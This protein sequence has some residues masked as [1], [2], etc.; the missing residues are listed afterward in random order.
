MLLLVI[1]NL[2]LLSTGFS[3]I[4]QLSGR[5]VC[6]R[7][8]LEVS[9]LLLLLMRGE[10]LLLLR[11]RAAASCRL[12]LLLLGRSLL[13][14]TLPP[15]LT[16]ATWRRN[17][18]QK[19]GLDVPLRKR[20]CIFGGLVAVATSKVVRLGLVGTWTREKNQSSQNSIFPHATLNIRGPASPEKKILLRK[21]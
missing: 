2:F 8:L 14:L 18:L 5:L 3:P 11:V 4:Y 19:L 20:C 16:P 9:R 1:I 6:W 21:Y 15:L 7:R 12:L 13:G 10:R 17:T